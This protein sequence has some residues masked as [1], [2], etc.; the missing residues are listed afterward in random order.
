MPALYLSSV[1]SGYHISP[2]QEIPKRC[3][4]KK[5]PPAAEAPKTLIKINNCEICGHAIR[6]ADIHR[7]TFQHRWAE[8]N[9]KWDAFDD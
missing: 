2:F 9:Q 8:K 5:V 3:W 4:L 7:R 6:N 1:Q